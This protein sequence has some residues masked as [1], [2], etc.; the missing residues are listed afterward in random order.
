MVWLYKRYMMWCMKSSLPLC[1]SDWPYSTVT[2]MLSTTW[3]SRSSTTSC[4]VSCTSVPQDRNIRT[5][6]GRGISIAVNMSIC[7]PQRI[8]NIL[9]PVTLCV[10]VSNRALNHRSVLVMWLYCRG[11]G[12]RAWGHGCGAVPLKPVVILMFG[13]HDA[14]P[15]VL[16]G[17]LSY[18]GLYGI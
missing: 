11:Q 3:A 8:W 15:H 2:A 10:E 5:M 4:K 16:S 18:F 12:M 14:W 7:P 17:T 6:G 1:S 13:M 9:M